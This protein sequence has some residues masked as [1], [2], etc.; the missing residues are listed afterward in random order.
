[1]I[2]RCIFCRWPIWPWQHVGWLVT[3]TGSV[4]RWHPRCKP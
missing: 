3:V 1:M 4:T 2:P